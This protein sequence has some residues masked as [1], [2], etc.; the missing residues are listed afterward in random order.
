M[1]SSEYDVYTDVCTHLPRLCPRLVPGPL[2]GLNLANIARAAP[3]AF[4]AVCNDCDKVV[5]EISRYWNSLDRSGRC[6]IC[7]DVGRD[8]DE[9]WR[10]R[11]YAEGKLIRGVARLVGLR[12][13]C[14]KCHLAKH[15]GY[16]KRIGKDR[17]ALEHLAEVNGVSLERADGVV[18]KAFKIWQMLNRIDDW[19]FEVGELPGVDEKLK[20][21]VE[22]LF[23][24]MWSAGFRLETNRPVLFHRG[25]RWEEIQDRAFRET[26][27][28]IIKT[29]SDAA[30]TSI[31][32]LADTLVKVVKRGLGADIELL[33][34]EFR[35]F[36]RI[37]SG[38][39]TSAIIMIES[40]VN[41]KSRLNDQTLN[42]VINNLANLLS[43]DF[44]SRSA[45][46][47]L[48]DVLV[49]K[50]IVYV[51][52]SVYPK[53]SRDIIDEL[54][55]QELEYKTE[56]TTR[57]NDYIRRHELPIIVY[58]PSTL[59]IKLVTDIARV[60]KGELKKHGINQPLYFKPDVFTEKGYYSRGDMKSYV[61]KTRDM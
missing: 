42:K 4:L 5:R 56:I 36:I 21:D 49:G 33:E 59:A 22:K 2:W 7:G 19:R 18:D 29:V 55:R 45:G 61:Y 20:R 43:I 13:L 34:R 53:L 15:Q 50:W 17:E 25:R 58:V 38:P 31:D 57:R 47:R 32:T 26:V 11:I 48:R 37:I 8:I 51:P 41:S 60:I 39:L 12:L 1:V 28:V 54:E 3:E 40:V 23:N 46:A 52:V 27:D 16:A 14:E 44:D 6:V 24:A 10:Y 30:G 35:E 9:D